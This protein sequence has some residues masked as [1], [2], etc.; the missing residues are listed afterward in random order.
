MLNRPL[1]QRL[2]VIAFLIMASLFVQAGIATAADESS[3]N[4]QGME[5]LTR[6][7]IHEAFADVSVDEAHPGSVISRSVPEP[8]NEIPPEFRPEGDH[9]EWISG[10]WSWDDDQNDFIWVSGI[11]RDVPPGRQW[12]PGYWMAVAGGNQYISGFWT[13]IEQ[14][15]TVYLPPPPTPL[16]TGPSSPSASLYQEWIAGHWVWIDGRYAWQAG[17]W[18]DERPN[19]VWIP[20]HYVWTPRGFVFV[21]G[22]WDYH[23]A[24]R[25]VLFAPRYYARPFYRNHGYYYT[26]RI[27]LDIDT[28]YLSLFIRRSSHHYYFGDYYDDRYVRR[29]FHPWHSA[30]AT[31]YGYDPYYRSYRLYRLRRDSHW[32]HNYH[33]HFQYRHDHREARPPI[34]YRSATHHYFDRSHGPASQSI[35]RPLAEVVKNRTRTVRFTRLTENHRREYQARDRKLSTYQG[36]RRKLEMTPDHG[37]RS[38]HSMNIKKPVQARMP[39][40]P[41]K[42][43]NRRTQ[44]YAKPRG[45]SSRDYEH[46]HGMEQKNQ[47]FNRRDHPE[48]QTR[49]P[50][51]GRKKFQAKVQTGSQPRLKSMERQTQRRQMPPEVQLQARSQGK[52]Q[53]KTKTQLEV[54]PQPRPKDVQHRPSRARPEMQL[55][56]KPQRKQQRTQ[57]VRNNTPPKV[58]QRAKQDYRPEKQPAKRFQRHPQVQRQSKRLDQYRDRKRDLR[59]GRQHNRE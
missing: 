25:G 45:K 44:R 13:D 3:A 36:E 28:I 49:I 39:A 58:Q 24:R 21:R 33:Q 12:I 8:I 10:Y 52:Q 23:F 20:A 14:K 4:E 7:P 1:L 18:L 9:V 11:W 43:E 56:A 41:I 27:V 53:R 32:E 55:R 54:Q 51:P 46:G 26:P 42:D 30:H 50:S 19:M 5:V 48:H 37:K 22:Y 38:R 17:Y 35:G 2:R 29:G 59:R 57:H 6:G 34:V 31:R 47:Q 40:S 16:Q 15:E